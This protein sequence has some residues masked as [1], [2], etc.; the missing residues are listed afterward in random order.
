MESHLESARSEHYG[1]ADTLLTVTALAAECPTLVAP[2]MDGGM[3]RAAATQENVR[4]L[5][6]RGVIFAGP[7]AGVQA[8]TLSRDDVNA[9]IDRSRSSPSGEA[10]LM[11]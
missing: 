4:I 7:A 6:E 3:Y 2:A 9:S 1:L 5:K 8:P 11:R 10:A